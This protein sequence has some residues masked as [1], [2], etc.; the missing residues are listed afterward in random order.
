MRGDLLLRNTSG[1]WLPTA[2]KTVSSSLV[3]PASPYNQ[4]NILHV[5]QVS[6]ISYSEDTLYPGLKWPENFIT[7]RQN[8][9][10]RRVR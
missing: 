4:E 7:T 3:E 6:Q 9:Y 5:L 2:S 10:R 8:T 1:I